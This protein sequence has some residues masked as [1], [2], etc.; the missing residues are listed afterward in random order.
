ML[1]RRERRKEGSGENYVEGNSPNSVLVREVT[2]DS[3]VGRVQY[4]EFCPT[5]KIPEPDAHELAKCAISS[6]KNANPGMD[7][8]TYLQNN[9]A[10]GIHTPLG[11]AYCDAVLQQ[12]G[13]A[14]LDEAL[15]RA[16]AQ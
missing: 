9:I 7:G 2:D 3:R 4:T 1:W 8:I 16:K 5:G 10:A 6:V 13:T 12:T 15:K 11:E 14:S